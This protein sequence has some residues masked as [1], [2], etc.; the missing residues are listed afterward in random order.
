MTQA[1]CKVETY[2][3]IEKVREYIQLFINKLYARGLEH[4]R[5]KLENP[6]LEVFTEYTPKLSELTY[7]SP[8]YRECL[9]KMNGALQHH[10]AQYRHH[11]EH[12]DNSINDMNLI[13]I[14]EMFCDWKAASERQLDGNLLKSIEKNANRF[15]MDPQLKRILINTAKVYDE[16]K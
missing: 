13:D 16:Q 2:K 9:E 14:V 11:P 8:E 3:H 6:E 15:N 4:D 10:Y 1:E 12:F 7:D 5:A